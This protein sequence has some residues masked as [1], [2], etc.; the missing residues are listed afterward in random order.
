MAAAQN[1]NL[2][3]ISIDMGGPCQ[4]AEISKAEDVTQAFLETVKFTCPAC[5]SSA[6]NIYRGLVNELMGHRVDENTTTLG[7]LSGKDSAVIEV[8]LTDNVDSLLE[9]DELKQRWKEMG[10]EIL[11][12]VAWDHDSVASK[13]EETMAK[14]MSLNDR[15]FLLMVCHSCGDPSAWDFNPEDAPGTFLMV[16]TMNRNKNRRKDLQYKVYPLDRVGV[17]L[18]DQAKSLIAKAVKKTCV[19]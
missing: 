14:L 17:T 6:I 15:R 8:C 19:R 1:G 5:S 9:H 10:F 3:E 4:V 2:G 13:Y 16:D 7:I 18:E 11:G 12:V